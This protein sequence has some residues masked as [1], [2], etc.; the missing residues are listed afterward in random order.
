MA[1]PEGL[2]P[3]GSTLIDHACNIDSDE[4]LGTSVPEGVLALCQAAL[5]QSDAAL[6]VCSSYAQALQFP[7]HLCAFLP[8]GCTDDALCDFQLPF[9]VWWEH[10]RYLHIE[11]AVRSN[12]VGTR[13]DFASLLQWDLT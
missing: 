4:D 7:S 9:R 1:Q 12:I 3:A 13:Y 8:E 6:L 5:Q 10:I 2:K 11:A